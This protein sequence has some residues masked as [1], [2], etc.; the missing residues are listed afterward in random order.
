MIYIYIY[1]NIYTHIYIYICVCDFVRVHKYPNK[2][3]ETDVKMSKAQ[4]HP[5]GRKLVIASE[6]GALVVALAGGTKKVPWKMGPFFGPKKKTPFL[7]D[8]T[9]KHKKGC[10]WIWGDLM[11]HK[12]FFL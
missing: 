11:I 12:C 2:K 10:S 4:R 6:E 8:V 3:V 5:P 1:T 7:G 9:G